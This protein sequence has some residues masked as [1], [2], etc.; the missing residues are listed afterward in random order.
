[1]LGL[2]LDLKN[3]VG[4]STHGA[5]NM[6]GRYKGFSSL[7]SNEAPMQIHVWCHAHVLNL[8]VTEATSVV[9]TSASLFSLLNDITAFFRESHQRMNIWSRHSTTVKRL[10]TIGPTRWWSKDAALKNVFGSFINPTGA[11][12]M[13]VITTLN[14]ILVADQIQAAVKAK[15]KGYNDSLKFETILTAQVYL[16]VFSRTTNVSKSTTSRQF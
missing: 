5:A 7:L 6:Q 2:N 4:N 16:Q 12:F 15:V 8:V 9:V 3:C 11:L 14:A 1:M 13:D 10:G